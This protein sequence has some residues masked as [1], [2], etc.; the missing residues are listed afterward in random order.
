MNFSV[1]GVRQAVASFDLGQEALR[2]EK[3]LLFNRCREHH[4]V[5]Q[6]Q[7]PARLAFGRQVTG[8]GDARRPTSTADFIA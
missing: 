7:L 4:I 2:H 5:P 6:R 8:S 3:A 1:C